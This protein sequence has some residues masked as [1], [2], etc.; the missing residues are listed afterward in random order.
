M[1]LHH[2]IAFQ[3]WEGAFDPATPALPAVEEGARTFGG[4]PFWRRYG[5]DDDYDEIREAERAAAEIRSKL[6]KK[7]Q[8]QI[9]D[10]INAA[11]GSILRN[12]RE[13]AYLEQVR[14]YEQII[15]EQ[16]GLRKELKQAIE[17]RRAFRAE[18]RRKLQLAE[19]ARKIE[20]ARQAEM[21]RIEAKRRAEEEE[22]DVLYLMFMDFDED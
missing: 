6:A 16:A 3:F 10:A 14:A 22:L 15:K 2:L 9:D 18:V 4:G 5:Y 11:A 1:N 12:E 21:A 7:R 8:A 13:E 19:Q 17:A 20:A